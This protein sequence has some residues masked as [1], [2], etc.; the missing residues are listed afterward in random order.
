MRYAP[1]ANEQL[2]YTSDGL[3]GDMVLTYDVRHSADGS[4]TEVNNLQS[5]LSQ[6]RLSDDDNSEHFSYIM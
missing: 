3:A 5:F 6:Y 1:S 4:Y 2:A